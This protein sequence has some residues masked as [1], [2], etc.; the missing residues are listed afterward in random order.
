MK[1]LLGSIIA[2]I[3]ILVAVPAMNVSA[4]DRN[5]FSISNYDIQYELS[6]DSDNRSVLKT[7][8]TITANFYRVNQ[9]HGIE[10][11]I[12]TSYNGHTTSLSIESVTNAD[13][14]AWNYTENLNSGVTVLRIGDADRYVEGMQ[15]YRIVYTQRDVTR[16]YAD[17]NRD[18]FYWDTNGTEWAVPIAQLSVALT[19][20]DELAENRVGEPFCYQGQ[21]G[22]SDPC[23]ILESS[24]T[25]YHAFASDLAA[26]ENVTLAL[27]FT[28]NTF[29]GYQPSLFERIM[30]IWLIAMLITGVFAAVM[31][32]VL[33]VV[34]YRKR[35]RTK[36]LHTIVV[37]YVPPKHTSVTLASQVVTTVGSVFGAQLIDF[38]VRH[39]IAIIETKPKGTWT[40]AEYD[41]EVLKD[42]STLLDEEKEILI[43][44][45]G[46]MPKVGERLALKSLR[47]NHSYFKRT[48]D[49]DAKL[50]RLIEGPYGLRE[51]SPEVSRFFYRW[52]TALLI[53]GVVTVS[54]PLLFVSIFAWLFGFGI[55]PLTNNGLEIRRYLLGLSKYIKAAEAERLKM[56]QGPDTAQ[57]VGHNVDT[58]KPG[59]LVKLY[60]RVL[61]YAILFGFE[62]DWTKRL[63]EFYETSQT[64]PS[65]YSG[66]TAFNAALFASSISSF[67]SS[68]SY[69][70]GMS[71]SSSSGGSS[72]GGFSGGGGGGGGGGGW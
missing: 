12:P 21:S 60:E 14:E 28:P 71:S 38:A 49:N 68:A 16:F 26:G 15:T 22:A 31:L 10:R 13:G 7:T 25:T 19:V 70:S 41:I 24:G 59:Q 47:N 3:A 67:S 39:F 32:V 23:S 61:P 44:M 36:E 33:T 66:S 45:F 58:S 1:R 11:A 35:N 69:S 37:Q 5:D 4:A 62:H 20:S 2:G 40:A 29:S 50:R 30:A 46:A 55:R 8:E 65:W 72:G 34:Y 43:D 18:E 9:N 17:T 6:K 42:P 52:A 56:L 27:G 54:M 57:K 48:T 64:N 63:G 51:K 53:I